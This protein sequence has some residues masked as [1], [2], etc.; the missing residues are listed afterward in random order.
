M[1]HTVSKISILTLFVVLFSWTAVTPA[2]AEDDIHWRQG[3][4]YEDEGMAVVISFYN[5]PKEQWPAG[6]HL[7]YDVRCMYGAGIDGAKIKNVAL[8]PHDYPQYMGVPFAIDGGGLRQYWG[9]GGGF[10]GFGGSIKGWGTTL[11]GTSN[12]NRFYELYHAGSQSTTVVVPQFRKRGS[13]GGSGGPNLNPTPQNPSNTGT[14][15]ADQLTK[16]GTAG[17][18][19]SSGSKAS[20]KTNDGAS[21]PDEEDPTSED[22]ESDDDGSALTAGPDDQNRVFADE[23]AGEV[24]VAAQPIVGG[25]VWI[26]PVAGVLFLAVW[27]A[28]AWYW[29]RM[30]R[31]SQVVSFS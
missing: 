21:T 28:V 14:P 13:G 4:C 22:A 8:A 29:F 26:W 18:T 27:S 24:I 2:Q 1:K 25:P 23:A 5:L 31:R 17:S 16:P 9:I 20:N 30:R 6:N 7:G 19:S 15:K 10:L 3:W 11:A 12:V